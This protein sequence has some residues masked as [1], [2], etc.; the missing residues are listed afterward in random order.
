MLEENKI[1]RRIEDRDRSKNQERY[2][3]TG[4]MTLVCG[5]YIRSDISNRSDLSDTT[6]Y[7]SS[8]QLTL[9]MPFISEWPESM[10]LR[11]LLALSSSSLLELPLII[12]GRPSLISTASTSSPENS[13]SSFSSSARDSSTANTN[14]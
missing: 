14:T 5:T 1:T 9:W 8:F 6:K 10:E 7:S 4:S 2:S 11:I 13:C 12:K 3:R